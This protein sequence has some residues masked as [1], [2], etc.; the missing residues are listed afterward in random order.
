MRGEYRSVAVFSLAFGLATFATWGL[1]EEIDFVN[2]F[3][4]EA[5]RWLSERVIAGRVKGRNKTTEC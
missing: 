1:G 2:T 3:V 5:L 4:R